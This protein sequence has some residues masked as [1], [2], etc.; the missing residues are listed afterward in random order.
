MPLAITDRR[1]A[2]GVIAEVLVVERTLYEAEV[3]IL[4]LTRAEQGEQLLAYVA[5]DEGGDVSTLL[6]PIAPDRV[7]DLESGILSVRDAL[8]AS[9]LWLHESGQT[10]SIEVDKVPG[11][12]LPLPGTPLYPEHE[13]VLRTRAVGEDVVLGKMPAS[14]VAFVADSTRKA[15]KT[16]LHYTFDAPQDGRPR[17]EHQALY[18][19]PIQSFAFASFELGF[20]APD[21]GL[22]PRE[23]VRRAAELLE[24]GLL[25]ACGATDLLDSVDE[26]RDAILAATLLLTPPASGPIRE[27][28]ISG[29]WIAHGKVELT[30]GSRRKIREELKTTDETVITD[31]G[32]IGEL[33]ADNL[34]FILRDTQNGNERRGSFDDDLLDDMH[35]F[36]QDQTQVIIA[37]IERRG[38]MKI[39]AIV[40]FVSHATPPDPTH[41]R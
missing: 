15:I 14:V 11:A 4:Y 16:L 1:A 25:Y 24:R 27:V 39:S 32:R 21:E 30:R 3:P 12:Y 41:D 17:K 8:T 40:K 31:T 10:W 6:A 38:K 29:T 19:L 33:D 36:F 2:P 23:Q 37:G 20:A 35:A 7:R 22:Y 5:H 9:W 28:L 13:P 18:D 34:S 26:E